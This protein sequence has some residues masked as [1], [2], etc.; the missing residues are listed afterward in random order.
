MGSV[1]DVKAGVQAFV[2]AGVEEIIMA[3]FPRFHR[4][5]LQRFSAEVVPAFK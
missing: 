1:E 2:D 3:Q 5:S 4:E